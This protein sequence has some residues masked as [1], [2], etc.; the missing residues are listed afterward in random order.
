MHKKIYGVVLSFY[1]FC[2]ICPEKIGQVLNHVIL[3][4]KLHAFFSFI[5]SI[6]M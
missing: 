2:I 4:H 3:E 6:V 1:V 5:N